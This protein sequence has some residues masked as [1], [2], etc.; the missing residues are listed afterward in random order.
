MNVRR[1]SA[2]K[3]FELATPAIFERVGVPDSVFRKSYDYY[4]NRPVEMERIYAVLVDS[5]SLREQRLI[6]TPSVE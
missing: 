3:I 6:T 5:L 2:E 4:V 1:D